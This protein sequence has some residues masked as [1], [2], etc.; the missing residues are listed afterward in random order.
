MKHYIRTLL[1]VIAILALCLMP[2][3]ELEIIDLLAFSFADFVA[4]TIM[5]MGFSFVFFLDLNK[6]APQH[7]FWRLTARVA[8]V[9]LIF[10]IG[11]ELLQLWL[12]FLNRSASFADWIFDVIGTAGGI[13]LVYLKGRLGGRAA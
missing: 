3:E 13:A 11:T 12:A 4:H 2:S 5:F 9:S 1:V 10:G 6:T 8:A 7:S